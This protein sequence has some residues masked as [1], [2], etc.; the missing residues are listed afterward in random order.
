MPILN[1]NVSGVWWSIQNIKFFKTNLSLKLLIWYL[2]KK[3]L[4]LNKKHSSIKTLFLFTLIFLYTNVLLPFLILLKFIIYSQRL[5]NKLTLNKKQSKAN[6][7]LR[8]TFSYLRRFWAPFLM[9]SSLFIRSLI[10]VRL[11]RAISKLTSFRFDSR[12]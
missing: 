11:R 3:K 6:T 5:Y 1:I 12:S 4:K 10:S 2:L 8:E 7:L 9:R